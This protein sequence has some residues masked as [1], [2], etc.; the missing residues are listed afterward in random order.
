MIESN[1]NSA[2]LS[3][4][5]SQLESTEDIR[6]LASKDEEAALRQATEQFESLFIQMMLKTMRST[7]GEEGSL[8]SSSATQTFRDLQDTEL[9]K[10]IA[11]SGGLGLTDQ[12]IDSVKR[13]AGIESSPETA[14][15]SVDEPATVEDTLAHLRL[16]GGGS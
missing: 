2:M 3:S 13:Q 4:M 9:S 11:A 14:S 16:R 12:L 8:F 1:V 5:Q 10:Q 7:V 6:L 15:E